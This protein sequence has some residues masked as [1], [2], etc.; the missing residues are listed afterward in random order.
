MA[1]TFQRKGIKANR[2]MQTVLVVAIIILESPARQKRSNATT[3]RIGHFEKLCRMKVT[4]EEGHVPRI[5][6]GQIRLT[7][8]P[9]VKVIVRNKTAR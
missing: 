4:K 8:A 3:K 6:V 1:V 5:I 9:T 7:K 2:T